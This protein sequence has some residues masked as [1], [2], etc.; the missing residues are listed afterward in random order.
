MFDYDDDETTIVDFNDSN[1]ILELGY[2]NKLRNISPLIDNYFLNHMYSGEFDEDSI[3]ITDLV[4]RAFVMALNELSEIGIVIDSESYMGDYLYMGKIYEFRKIFDPIVLRN[5]IINNP[6]MYTELCNYFESIDE[7]SDLS[8]VLADTLH[9][10]SEFNISERNIY[11][12]LK[13]HCYDNIICKFTFITYIKKILTDVEYAVKS[14]KFG[15]I[16]STTDYIKRIYEGRVNFAHAMQHVCT[17][18]NIPINN[19][20]RIIVDNYDLDKVQFDV[21]KLYAYLDHEDKSIDD[22]PEH[23]RDLYT[24]LIV[25]RH[26]KN[27][28]HHYEYWE[29]RGDRVS[30]PGIIATLVCHHYS[31][32]KT[33][34][35]ML[36]EIEDLRKI[37]DDDMFEVAVLMVHQLG[38]LTTEV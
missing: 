33:V 26:H 18:F 28:I 34:K 31:P 13:V 29:S 16:V 36:K 10:M 7:D 6:D 12:N 14:T 4:S 2:I 3:D 11:R 35:R 23:M 17:R 15:D 25:E 5:N 27:S 9:I 8:D 24:D 21:V 37:M 1:H 20:L 22:Y 38:T 32:N 30:D 19:T